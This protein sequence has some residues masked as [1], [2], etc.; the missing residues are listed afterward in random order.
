MLKKI[1][2]CVWLF[3]ASW[4]MTAKNFTLS[5]YVTDAKNGENLQNASVQI[6]DK[7]IGVNTN[8]YGYY[9]LTLAEGDYKVKVSFIGY[10]SMEQDVT[11]S[12][13]KKLDIKLSPRNVM[14]KEIIVRSKKRKDENV[15]TTQVGVHQLS[16]EN[17]KK[18][19]VILGEVD[20]LKAIQ[21]VKN[22]G[23]GSSGFYVRGG[24]PD[25]NLI[26][27]DDAVVYNTG[28]LFGFFS[29][30]NGDAIKSVN[31]IKGGMP[32]NYGGRLSSVLDVNMKEGNNKNFRV[33]GGIGLIA[34]RLSVQGPIVKEKGSFII[35]GRRTYATELLKVVLPNN[36]RLQNF[37]YYF[38][39]FNAKANY[40]L[41]E[42]DRLYLSAYTGDDVFNFTNAEKTFGA[43]IP[44]GN[45]TATLRWNHLFNSKLFVNTTAVYNKYDFEFGGSQQGFNVKL[46]SGIRDWNLKTDFDYFANK[47][48]IKF[49]AISTYHRLQPSTFSGGSDSVALDP[50]NPVVKY[51]L[52]SAAYVQ[53]DFD[54]TSWLKINAGLRYSNFLHLG[55]YTKYVK[56]N[57]VNIDSTTYAENN[58]VKAYGGLEPR[59]NMR[60][61]LDKTSSIKTSVSRNLQYIH[62]V[63]NNGS[64][65]PTDIWVP[66]TVLV[67]PQ[68]SWQYSA[69]Y[70]KNFNDNM[71]ETSV[72]VY[73]KDMRN[74]LEYREG[75]TPN[76]NND[77]EYE[78][79]VGRGWAYG[80]EFFV[81]KTK[82]RWTGWLGYT[83]S[84]TRRQFDKLNSTEP[85]LAKYDR[86]HDISLTSTYE[87]NKNLTLSGVFIFS[88]GNRVT[89][90]TNLTIQDQ[91]LIA[92]YDVLNNQQLPPYNRL[93]LGAVW[94]PN[95]TSTRKVK[96]TWTFGVYNVYNRF[97]PYIIY[98]DASGNVNQ[99]QSIKIKAISVFPVIPSVT[100]NFKI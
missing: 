68:K 5:G 24:G 82:G 61:S 85:F 21:L 49:G 19:P 40:K 70:F 20:V 89:L 25:Q 39:D 1:S 14:Q 54:A 15:K 86:R 42:N 84:W 60:F 36:E 56:S 78:F 23:E 41:G 53:D 94:V 79:V 45:R 8:T 46:K 38:Y 34:S 4:T 95:P 55:P 28:H 67:Q 99:S 9:S 18:L 59:L 90:P 50:V 12:A 63:T 11:I 27:L 77:P 16:V 93:D 37:G 51:A 75:Y 98:L 7:N 13:N 88:S 87:L 65:L 47:H 57:G 92:Q 2:L 17:I 64:T 31:L 30:F 97:N 100:W 48:T 44:W 81:N 69:G 58:V 80:A 91:T 26:L 76:N 71:V 52:E 33:D 35:C 43:R 22:A 32:A 72:E 29:V 83:L 10:E 73:Y 66:S 62:L 3:I 6:L 96:S 74:Q